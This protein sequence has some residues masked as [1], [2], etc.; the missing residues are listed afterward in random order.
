MGQLNFISLKDYKILR[1]VFFYDTTLSN[2]NS[3]YSKNYKLKL[4][5]SLHSLSRRF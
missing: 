3:T 5:S 1:R 4:D 2:A